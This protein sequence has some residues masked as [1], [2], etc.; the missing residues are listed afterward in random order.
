METT[1]A[2]VSSKPPSPL[3]TRFPQLKPFLETLEWS[4][5]RIPNKSCFE[6]MGERGDTKHM[7]DKN[8]PAEV[9]AARALFN[10]LTGKRSDGGHGYRA[11]HVKGKDG[12]PAEQMTE[13][14]P[15]AERI[16]FVGP[17]QGG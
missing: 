5:E 9:D 14:E 12:E 1:I 7:W 10:S 3:I 16:I 4:D 13:F 2:Q 17:K 15:D 8:K 6:I 11:F